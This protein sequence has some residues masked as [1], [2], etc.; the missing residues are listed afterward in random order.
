MEKLIIQLVKIIFCGMKRV[1]YHIGTWIHDTYNT[2]I[3]LGIWF[4]LNLLC[5]P[6]LHHLHIAHKQ[7][8]TLT[9]FCILKRL[10]HDTRL[11]AFFNSTK[12]TRGF[13]QCV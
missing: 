13:C 3:S 2:H 9:F 8:Q 1:M 6:W 7:L 10:A 11:L 4:L 12:Q 5:T